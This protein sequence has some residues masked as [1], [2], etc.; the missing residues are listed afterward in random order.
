[1]SRLLRLNNNV[2]LT[3]TGNACSGSFFI[4]DD[5]V[6]NERGEGH[7][8]KQEDSGTSGVNAGGDRTGDSNQPGDH[9]GRFRNY[10]MDAQW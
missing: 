5:I 3:G 4:S 7:G 1:M 6:W 8:N 9:I 2:S 10:G